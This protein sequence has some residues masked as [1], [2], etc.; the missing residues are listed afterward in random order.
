MY[1]QPPK[2]FYAVIYYEEHSRIW[3]NEI[4]YINSNMCGLNARW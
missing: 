4:F 3:V 2:N 1:L